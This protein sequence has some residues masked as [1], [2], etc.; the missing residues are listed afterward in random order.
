MAS[1]KTFFGSRFTG[2]EV[3]FAGAN[4]SI[5]NLIKKLSEQVNQQDEYEYEESKSPSAACALFQ[6]RDSSSSSKTA[7]LKIY[8]QSAP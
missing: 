3:K 4:P 8:M 1:N 6:C 5:W 2:S 7:I